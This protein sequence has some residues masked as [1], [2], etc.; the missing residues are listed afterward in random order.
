MARSHTESFPAPSYTD[1]EVLGLPPTAQRSGSAGLLFAGLLLGACAAA[2]YVIPALG[3]GHARAFATAGIVIAVLL[4]GVLFLLYRRYDAAL[5]DASAREQ[6]AAA[7]QQRRTRELDERANEQENHYRTATA[8]LQGALGHLLNVQIPAALEGSTVPQS[9]SGSVTSDE[10]A[11]LC[12][13]VAEA[14]AE[15]VAKLR[16]QHGDREESSRL[17]VLALAR[18]LQSS[19]HRI[20][21]EATTLAE[22]YTAD[23]DVLEFSMRVDHAAAQQSRNAQSLAVLCGE[24]PGQQW[25]EP[26]A[27]LD[28]VRAASGRIMSYKRINVSG[29][30]GIAAAA[31]VVEPLIHLVAEL[32]ANA[33]QSSPPTTKVEVTVRPVRRGAVIEIDDPGVG[34]EDAQFDQ[35]RE[36]ISGARS[37]GL[38]DLGEIPQTGL[39]VIGQYV[40]RHGFQADLRPSP[41]GGVRAIVLVPAEM[42]ENVEPA[43]SPPP[44]PPQQ[45][46]R[47]RAPEPSGGVLSGQLPQRRSP[48]GQVPSGKHSSPPAP[49]P[50]TAAVPAN[51]P[52]QDGMFL[53][54]FLRSG[55]DVGVPDAGVSQQEP[56]PG[57]TFPSAGGADSTETER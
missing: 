4:A 8:R 47:A 31:T 2:A 18:L 51:T 32:L 41:Y 7:Q 1:S 6:D 5:A 46:T 27:L 42:V 29:D 44:P 45:V 24:W 55:A 57:S 48:R 33:T 3:L 53:D 12:D 20:Q 21:S 17:A 54:A 15:G 36:I 39:P 26:L 34:M 13:R 10:I 37:V 19:A 38:G 25:P 35:A 50:L 22:A 9:I 43:A 40:R 49:S 28:V 52:E 56:D 11:V 14:T 16:K 23:P 30:P